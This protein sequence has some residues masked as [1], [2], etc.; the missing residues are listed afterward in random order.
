[1]NVTKYIAYQNVSKMCANR[2]LILI[3]VV[4][5]HLLEYSEDK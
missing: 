3:I 1:M 5:L 2:V 4:H